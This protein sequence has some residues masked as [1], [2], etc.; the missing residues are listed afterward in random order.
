MVIE[1]ISSEDPVLI[2]EVVCYDGSSKKVHLI[3]LNGML[4]SSEKEKN[5]D[6]KTIP[7]RVPVKLIKE[8][9]VFC[10]LQ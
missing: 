3:N 2:K 10:L 6:L 1:I 4:I 7:F 8:R 5:L 9:I